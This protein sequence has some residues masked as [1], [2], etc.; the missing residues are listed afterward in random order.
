MGSHLGGLV[1][2]NRTRS[3]IHDNLNVGDALFLN[4]SAKFWLAGWLA[5][6]LAG[7]LGGWVSGWLG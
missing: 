2:K 6:W 4:L 5:A 3:V 1:V 7:W